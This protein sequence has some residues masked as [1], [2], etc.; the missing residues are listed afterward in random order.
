M[1]TERTADRLIEQYRLDRHVGKDTFADTYLA[2][3]LESNRHVLVGILLA[4]FA[5]E[6]QFRQHYESRTSALSLLHHPNI[7]LIYQT[8]VTVDERPYIVYEQVEGYPLADRLDRLAQQQIPAHAIY[9]LRLIRQIAA[10]LSLAERLGYYHYELTPK[11]ILLRNVTLK[12]DDSVVIIDLDFPPGYRPLDEVN[13]LAYLTGYLSPEQLNGREIDGRSLVYSL[14]VILFELL[15][16]CRP[17]EVQDR[18]QRSL[19]AMTLT[20]AP[21][22]RL[23]PELTSETHDLVEKALRKSPRGRYGSVAEFLDALN[24]ALAAEDLRIHTSDIG[25][26]NRPRPVFLLPLLLLLACLAVSAGL[27]WIFPRAPAIESQSSGPATSIPNL[28]AEAGLASQT[29]TAT[30]PVATPSAAVEN[31][32]DTV[33]SRDVSA[34]TPTMQSSATPVLTATDT[35]A[36]VPTFTSTPRDPTV[37][38]PAPTP[39]PEFL[40]SAGSASLRFGPSTRFGV[41]SYLMKDDRVVILGKNESSDL[42]YVVQTADGRV[43]WIS[44][45][46]GEPDRAI[47]LNYVRVAATIPPPPP[48][49]TPTPTTTPTP[50]ATSTL[51]PV[52]GSNDGGGNNDKE[53][54]PRSTPTPPL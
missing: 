8:G 2:Y 25:N 24:Q 15:T 45:I 16:G 10:G 41:D 38:K 36:S 34:L 7:A 5:E 35:P 19:R 39:K 14:G 12:S 43:G 9:A 30:R 40:I 29:A 11:H 52:G 22:Q 32:Q 28:A 44:A 26:P 18:R 23:R 46:V 1:V 21:L 33:I 48:T 20:S 17:N 3:D 53:D 4:P 51:A 42:W 47:A 37:T 13:E 6:Y 49:F 31:T 50:T 27:W 54:K